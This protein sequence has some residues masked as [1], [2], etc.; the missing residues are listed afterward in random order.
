MESDVQVRIRE[1]VTTNYLFGDQS[2][3]PADD[4][5]LLLAGI[6][7]STG[8]LELIEYLESDFGIQVAES[9]TLPSNLGSI[10]NI[11]RYVSGKSA[12]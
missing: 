2:R 7:D 12:D 11:T 8:I 10:A 3:V 9:E 6:V 1:F 5:D 4:E